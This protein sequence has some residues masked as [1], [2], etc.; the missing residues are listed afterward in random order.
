MGELDLK[1]EILRRCIACNEQKDKRDLLRIVKPKDGN[2]EIDL[3]GKKNGRGAYICK[4]ENC[5]NKAIKTKKLERV[6]EVSIDNE[7][8]E[9]IRGVIVE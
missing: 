1:K 3:I 8:Y 4:D 6:F 9:S 2:L 7:F 5:L